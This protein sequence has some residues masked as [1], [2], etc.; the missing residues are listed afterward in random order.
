MLDL[1][2]VVYGPY[3]TQLLGDFGADVIKI[4]R[5]G[6]DSTRMV[7][8]ERN[9]GMAALYLGMNRNKRSLVLDLKRAPARQALWRLIEGAD[10][11]VHNVR[12]QKMA[13][14][15]FDPDSVMAR[16]PDIVYGGLH[17]YR[18]EGPLW[19]PAGL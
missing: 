18:E 3:T 15:G 19:R 5:P 8:P 10:M 4:E 13:A 6:G 17:G 9:E 1:T 7:G 2:T 14:L 12:P 11:F 16:K